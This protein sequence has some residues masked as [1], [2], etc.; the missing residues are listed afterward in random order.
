MK[1][2]SDPLFHHPKPILKSLCLS[3]GLFVA[4]APDDS[5]GVKEEEREEKEKSNTWS[6]V[7]DRQTE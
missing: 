1:H 7:Y 4:F 5:L 6:P 3:A 2:Y